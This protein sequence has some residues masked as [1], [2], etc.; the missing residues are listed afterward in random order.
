M[1]N[2]RKFVCPATCLF[3]SFSQRKCT[4]HLCPYLTPQ[5]VLLFFAALMAFVTRNFHHSF[6]E[7]RSLLVSVWS[8]TIPLTPQIMVS[9]CSLAFFIVMTVVS[10][11]DSAP[12]PTAGL[13]AAAP[14]V[15]Q[16][17][18]FLYESIRPICQSL[19]PVLST[20]LFV[21]IPRLLSAFRNEKLSLIVEEHARSV[22]LKSYNEDDEKFE[23]RLLHL[24][25]AEKFCRMARSVR[26]CE[27][28]EGLVKDIEREMSKDE[29]SSEGTVGPTL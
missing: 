25:E 17:S 20:L 27:T 29:L 10:V 15:S 24:F 2:L 6:G 22:V 23:D 5:M 16:T 13:V 11:M 26:V 3:L 14:V 21:V 4:H 1:T 12:S 28:L 19:L 18:P 7:T 8:C 9:L